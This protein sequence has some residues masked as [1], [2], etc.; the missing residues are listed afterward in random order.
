MRALRRV[1]RI[2]KSRSVHFMTCLALAFSAYTGSVSAATCT[3]ATPGAAQWQ[4]TGFTPQ[5]GVFSIT[6]QAQPKASPG[7]TLVALAQGV[8]SRWSGLAAIVR[9]NNAGAID[10]RDGGVYRADRLFT[11]YAG[12]VYRLR[13]SVDMSTKT[14]SVYVRDISSERWYNLATDYKFRSEQQAISQLDTFVTEA[15]VGD[16]QGCVDEPKA[17]AEATPGAAQWQNRGLWG[18]VI[19]D[20]PGRVMSWEVRPMAAN[21]DALFALSYGPQTSWSGL[22]T[23][24]RFNSNG[25]IDARNGDHYTADQVVPYEPNRTYRL[26]MYVDMHGD[27]LSGYN[28]SYG[29]DIRLPTGE[30]VPIARNY[31]FRTE[32]QNIPRLSNW[33]LEAEQG[34][35]RGSLL[36]NWDP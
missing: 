9:F 36:E 11:Y 15:E 1:M 12:D 25:T 22:A 29:V 34:G 24:V 18:N 8:Q 26:H 7:D 27:E 31:R 21:S 14:Y 2:G 33:V 4:N 17:W 13:I 5:T 23:I 19:S 3:T 6:L 35:I 16:I 28:H 10:V 30:V 32:Q 20:L